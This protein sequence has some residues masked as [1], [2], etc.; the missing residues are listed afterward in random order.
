MHERCAACLA[1]DEFQE[2]RQGHNERVQSKVGSPLS[3]HLLIY[4][5]RR[6]PM[7]RSAA[8]GDGGG[9]WH[10]ALTR[11]RRCRLTHAARLQAICILVDA[12]AHDAYAQVER[13]YSAPKRSYRESNTPVTTALRRVHLKSGLILLQRVSNVAC[14]LKLA[15]NISIYKCN[16]G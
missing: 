7:E 2:R 4:A 15:T 8:V 10:G 6:Q 13:V 14:R 16:F 3:A 9:R 5:V 12:A 11:T 1:E